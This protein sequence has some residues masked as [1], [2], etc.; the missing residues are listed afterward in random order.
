MEGKGN[1]EPPRQSS[2]LDRG[3]CRND[4]L[5][6][7]LSQTVGEPQAAGQHELGAFAAGLCGED[8]P[9]PVHFPGVHSRCS[10]PF[11]GTASSSACGEP[12]RDPDSAGWAGI[13]T[14]ISFD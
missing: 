10:G 1:G 7:R 12:A 5:D 14:R 8:S 6:Q 13:S 4:E 11:L 2:R 9:M 3:D